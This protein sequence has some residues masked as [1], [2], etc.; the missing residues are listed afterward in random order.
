M[1]NW[2]SRDGFGGGF[3]MA[4]VMALAKGMG[5]VQNIVARI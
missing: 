4:L 1:K 3:E 2:F 5:G